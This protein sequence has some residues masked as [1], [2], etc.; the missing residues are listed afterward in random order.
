MV[1]EKVKFIT[2]DLP[3][4]E[5]QIKNGKQQ[6]NALLEE[7]KRLSKVIA[8]SDSFDFGKYGRT[9]TYYNQTVAN[10]RNSGGTC[11]RKAFRQAYSGLSS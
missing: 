8:K 5:E 9:R 7:E 4:L 2:K 11:Q 1:T 3:C 6:L 10:G